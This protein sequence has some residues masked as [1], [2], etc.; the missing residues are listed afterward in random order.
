MG[1]HDVAGLAETSEGLVATPSVFDRLADFVLRRPV[2]DIPEAVLQRARFLLLDTLGVAIAA[3]PM[4]AGRIA[5][6]AAPLLYGCQRSSATR[7]A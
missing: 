1:V 6:D 3:G 5:R 4:D 7:R 2:A